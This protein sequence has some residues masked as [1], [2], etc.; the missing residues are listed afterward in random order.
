MISNNLAVE[1]VKVTLMKEHH[2]FSIN[3]LRSKSYKCRF[4][5]L[6]NN[7]RNNSIKWYI[8]NLGITLRS[9]K[10]GF[11]NGYKPST[12]NLFLNV[13]HF[14]CVNKMHGEQSVD[15]HL[16]A[17]LL[18]PRGPPSSSLVVLLLLLLPLVAILIKCP[19][20]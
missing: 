7:R 13:L 9:F 8:R 12:S 5:S 4:F 20:C 10:F 3:D 16:S 19:S 17:S 1:S 14:L 11:R 18:W 2:I 15:K 6:T